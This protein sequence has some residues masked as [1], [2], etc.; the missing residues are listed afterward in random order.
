M[1]L[2]GVRLRLTPAAVASP[3]MRKVGIWTFDPI[4][5]L[6]NCHI[7]FFMFQGEEDG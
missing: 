3:A 2:F 1:T 6:S 5:L 7:T 4:F